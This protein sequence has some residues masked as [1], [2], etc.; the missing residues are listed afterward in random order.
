MPYR[1]GLMSCLTLSE[2]LMSVCWVIY[3]Q[4]LGRSR[5]TPFVFSGASQHSLRFT[6]GSISMCWVNEWPSQHRHDCYKLL[7]W[8]STLKIIWIYQS[9]SQETLSH[10]IGF[11]VFTIHL[12]VQWLLGQIAILQWN[13]I[14]ISYWSISILFHIP[15][16]MESKMR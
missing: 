8:N 3:W 5:L 4:V 9:T 2:P 14:I 15:R 1:K 7:G 11:W 10:P 16:L 12:F 6:E 13:R